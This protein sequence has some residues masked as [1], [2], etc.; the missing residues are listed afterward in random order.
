[1]KALLAPPALMLFPI[2]FVVGCASVNIEHYKISGT[3]IAD[4]RNLR[5]SSP[6]QLKV[7]K[8]TSYTPGNDFVSC[9][10]YGPIQ[11]P[12]GQSYESYIQNA[13]VS[14][15]KDAGLYSES[16]RTEIYGH[17]EF[18][19]LRTGEISSGSMVPGSAGWLIRMKFTIAG[20]DSFVVEN[21]Y[22][23]FPAFAA[24]E[25]CLQ[26]AQK[27][28]PAVQ[29]LLRQLFNHSGFREGIQTN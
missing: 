2:V 24:D 4:L 18:M 17:M 9:R 28:V 8:F 23:Y 19:E 22:R 5:Q 16:A 11:P 6:S 3:N 26:A 14:E 1:M 15:L 7:G 27:F 12:Q 29:D 20:K 10:M 13:L 25:A 21:M